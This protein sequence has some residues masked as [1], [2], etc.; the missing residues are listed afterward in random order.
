MV[1]RNGSTQFA[2][3][4]QLL[5]TKM[6][7]EQADLALSS[8]AEA[9]KLQFTQQGGRPSLPSSC[10]QWKEFRTSTK[11]LLTSVVNC[12]QQALPNGW[13]LEC[14]KPPR[15]LLPRTSQGD[16]IALLE[17]EKQAL[18]LPPETADRNMHFVYHFG[19]STSWPDFVEH[20]GSFYKLCLAADEGTE[21]SCQT[22]YFLTQWSS[23]MFSIKT[24]KYRYLI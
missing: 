9:F 8:F 16:R 7:Q 19:E 21:A 10:F 14:C 3:A 24:G 12:L 2:G 17:S 22:I 18:G 11:N 23:S 20:P 5:P 13:T 4:T 15:L 6:C 1:F